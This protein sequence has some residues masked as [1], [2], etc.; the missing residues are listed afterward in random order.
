[1]P[2]TAGAIRKQRAD[3]KKARVNLRIKKALREAVLA[4]KKKPTD[5]NLKNVFTLADRAAKKRVIHKNKAGRIK[6]RLAGLVVNKKKS[7]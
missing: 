5:K 2:I 1:M 7:S 3:Q 6:S 4:M